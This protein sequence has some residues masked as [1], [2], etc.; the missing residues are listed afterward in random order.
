[1]GR[2]KKVDIPNKN[3]NKNGIVEF[4]K[5]NIPKK[6]YYI[7]SDEKERFAEVVKDMVKTDNCVLYND[8]IVNKSR[9]DNKY[10]DVS[11]LRFKEMKISEEG[12]V[13]EI[14]HETNDNMDEI[15]DEKCG[16]SIITEL[17]LYPQQMHLNALITY[18]EKI[19]D[20]YG[21]MTICP[22]L[23]NQWLLPNKF[24]ILETSRSGYILTMKC[25]L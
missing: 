25:Y 9:R 15:N 14:N 1:M 22:S 7:L 16:S 20:E 23:G 19:R 3:E 12:D 10:E 4:P 21:N 6:T 11:Q 17:E 18:F 13:Q 24:Q 8:E 5:F 2:K